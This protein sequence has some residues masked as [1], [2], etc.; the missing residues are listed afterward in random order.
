MTVL[1][2]PTNEKRSL[3]AVQKNCDE[4]L[5]DHIMN[6]IKFKH[7]LSHNH[8]AKVYEVFEEQDQYLVIYEEM[9]GGDLHARI[10]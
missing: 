4:E 10:E 3:W 7:T 5:M 2:T 1:H 6:D 8:I 9:A